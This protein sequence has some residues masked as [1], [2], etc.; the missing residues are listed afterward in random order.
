MH[1]KS[2]K[3]YRTVRLDEQRRNFAVLVP[4]L[5]NSVHIGRYRNIFESRY[6]LNMGVV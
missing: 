3:I 5:G 2:R 6:F 4:K 1:T